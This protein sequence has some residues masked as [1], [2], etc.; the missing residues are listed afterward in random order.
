[1]KNLLKLVLLLLVVL[2]IS[3]CY[4][5]Q[6]PSANI[7]TEAITE[8]LSQCEANG[9]SWIDASYQSPKTCAQCGETEGEALLPELQIIERPDPDNHENTLVEHQYREYHN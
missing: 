9:H 3:G 7:P 6:Q 4:P 8:P 2:F 1:M 5:A